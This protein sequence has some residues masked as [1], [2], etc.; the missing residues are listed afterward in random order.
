MKPKPTSLTMRPTLEPINTVIQGTKDLD[1]VNQRLMGSGVFYTRVGAVNSGQ[2]SLVSPSTTTASPMSCDILGSG[3]S[4]AS[5][6]WG[7][8][9]FG[10][11]K[12]ISTASDPFLSLKGPRPKPLNVI[13]PD[14]KVRCDS[15]DCP[16]K[17]IPHNIGRYFDDGVRP[18]K[19]EA[20]DI[21]RFFNCT[22]PPPDICAAYM[23]MF[24]GQ[25]SQADKDKVRQYQKHHMWS[26]INSE[27]STPRLCDSDGTLPA[28]YAHFIATESKVITSHGFIECSKSSEAPLIPERNPLRIQICLPS[29]DEPIRQINENERGD[30]D[31]NSC[32]S[33]DLHGDHTEDTVINPRYPMAGNYAD[34]NDDEAPVSP[35]ARRDVPVGPELRRV[36]LQLQAKIV[37]QIGQ[38]VHGPDSPPADWDGLV[39]EWMNGTD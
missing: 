32:A 16:I 25:G 21:I 28:S 9:I 31:D 24:Y 4:M 14:S 30:S 7:Y 3:L 33:D 2:G 8:D 20:D 6:V 27:P 19:D 22:V 39:A 12:P 5:S 23:R 17:G 1:Y 29:A 26:P 15:P 36:H 38:L 34:D 10:D 11:L 13:S 18:L 35:G 37:G